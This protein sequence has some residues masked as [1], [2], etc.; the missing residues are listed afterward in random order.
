MSVSG[1]DK[2]VF[3]RQGSDMLCLVAK[4]DSVTYLSILILNRH[5]IE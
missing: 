3:I 5:N 2:L 4:A 1:I